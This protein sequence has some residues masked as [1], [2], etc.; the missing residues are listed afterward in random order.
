MPK[1]HPARMSFLQGGR[2]RGARETIRVQGAIRDSTTTKGREL[3][4]KN[5][6]SADC[7]HF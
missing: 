5:G 1:N 4:T 2:A 7:W 6:L 3:L